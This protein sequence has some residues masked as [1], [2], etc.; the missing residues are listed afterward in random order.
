MR[1]TVPSFLYS[2]D[3]VWGGRDIAE[4]WSGATA[5]DIFVSEGSVVN[6][7]AHGEE[8][9]SR[10]QACQLPSSLANEI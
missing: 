6:V 3:A 4:F 9:R 8:E 5:Y 7:M 10:S 2:T 1:E